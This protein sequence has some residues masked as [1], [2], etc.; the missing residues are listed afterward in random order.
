M[1]SPHPFD[2]MRREVIRI[3]ERHG[4][5]PGHLS[6][7]QTIPALMDAAVHEL[8]RNGAPA[9]N[10]YRFEA[11]A[12]RRIDE[13]ELESLPG[14]VVRP[15][16]VELLGALEERSY[17]VGVL[18]RS[19]A[20]FAHEALKKTGLTRFVHTLRTRSESGPAKPDPEALLL[21]LKAMDVP[22]NRAVYVGDH[23]LDAECAMR[24]RVRFFALLPPHPN[25]LGTDVDRF[26]A[27]GAAAIA[28]S[29]AD[30]GRQLGF[31][32]LPAL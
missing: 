26:K 3:A 21:T 29:L 11:E 25:A 10:R 32:R 2:R 24:A 5:A 22:P 18:T 4:V 16:A 23:L 19:C 28:P 17:R 9:G 14:T 31:A 27:A 12:T 1:L 7:T 8:E 13:I 30:L 6:I 15:G 20:T